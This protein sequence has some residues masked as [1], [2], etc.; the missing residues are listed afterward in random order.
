MFAVVVHR[1]TSIASVLSYVMLTIA[2]V[3]AHKRIGLFALATGDEVQQC[4]DFVAD[5]PHTNA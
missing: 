3:R 1:L 4:Q 2:A 5:A